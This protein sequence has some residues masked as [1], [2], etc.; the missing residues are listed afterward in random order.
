MDAEVLLTSKSVVK[1]LLLIVIMAAVLFIGPIVPV[2][3]HSIT[4][5][6]IEAYIKVPNV[7]EE[8]KSLFKVR[9]SC[10]AV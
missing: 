3:W 7:E 6:T 10:F 8:M 9:E 2:P 4:F 1:F 5:R